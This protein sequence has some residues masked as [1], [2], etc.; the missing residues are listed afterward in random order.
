MKTLESI[1]HE[2][3][4]AAVERIIRA[5]R[6]AAFAAFEQQ[7]HLFDRQPQQQQ[8]AQPR[9][10]ASRPPT[11]KHTAP[12]RRPEEIAALETQLLAAVRANPGGTMAELAPI[13]GVKSEDLRVPA[14][15]LKAKKQ[16]KL[17]GRRQFTRYFP[18]DG[19]GVASA[20]ADASS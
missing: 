6:A 16:L 12:Q 9:A 13:V 7:F 8:A 3:V 19:D 20:H 11:R 17:V 14:V 2:E 5:S 4:T 15:R 1:I 18:V 10:T